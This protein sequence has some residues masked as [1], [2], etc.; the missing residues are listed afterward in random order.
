MITA[1]IAAIQGPKLGM[2]SETAAI[3]ASSSAN[4]ANR[5]S[6][7]LRTLIPMNV[8]TPRIAATIASARMYVP[9]L[10]SVMP[11]TVSASSRQRGGRTSRT[12][13]PRPAGRRARRT[14]RT[15]A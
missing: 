12:W 15:A 3:T 10:L 6:K 8:I 11:M 5:G 1:G 7:M 2:N 4:S 14:G 13:R 9:K